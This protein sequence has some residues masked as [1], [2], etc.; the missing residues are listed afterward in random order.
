MND[1]SCACHL[2]LENDISPARAVTPRPSATATIIALP[3]EPHGQKRHRRLALTDGQV[4]ASHRI[5]LGARR[6]DRVS[7]MSGCSMSR[8]SAT[9]AFA[10]PGPS[11]R[12]MEAGWWRIGISS[13]LMGSKAR[14][15]AR[16][17]NTVKP[18][19]CREN[20]E[21]AMHREQS[22]RDDVPWGR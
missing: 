19:I 9:Y 1:T 14:R 20:Q 17:G 3:P 13:S 7:T 10:P 11:S 5:R 4:M 12:A 15:D 2:G 21:F 22:L 16:L 8:F 6:R 18:L